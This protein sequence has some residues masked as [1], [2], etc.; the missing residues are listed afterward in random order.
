M[1]LVTLEGLEKSCDELL[2]CLQA[3][4]KSHM[5]PWPTNPAATSAQP[6]S[7][8]IAACMARIA[9]RLKC[10]NRA[11]STAN[12]DIVCGAHWL[13]MPHHMDPEQRSVLHNLALEA[14]KNLVKVFDIRVDKHLMIFIRSD[15]HEMYERLIDSMECGNVLLGDLEQAQQFLQDAEQTR[16]PV[17][18]FPV[19]LDRVHLPPFAIDNPIDLSSV[20][21]Q[22]VQLVRQHLQP[23]E[24]Q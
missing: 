1:I 3:K 10:L 12:N 11:Q 7:M 9:V 5:L 19:R 14:S 23:K 24:T 4:L 2:K 15:P 8:E 20:A 21:D 17:S 13:Q 22:I 18:V 16:F 6:P